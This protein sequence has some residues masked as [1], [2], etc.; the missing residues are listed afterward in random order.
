M[1][2]PLINALRRNLEQSEAAGTHERSKKLRARI[3][4][5]EKAPQPVAPKSDAA[6]ST[7]TVKK[8][9]RARK[10][11]KATKSRKR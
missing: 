10:A 11:Q 7:P 1:S 6:A 2:D 9:S 4:E 3:G 8:A 5:L